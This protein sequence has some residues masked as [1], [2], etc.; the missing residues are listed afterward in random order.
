MVPALLEDKEKKA[1]SQGATPLLLI[2]AQ[3][4]ELS[5]ALHPHPFGCA[6]GRL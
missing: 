5:I 4:V 6:Q 2:A 3:K 1:Y